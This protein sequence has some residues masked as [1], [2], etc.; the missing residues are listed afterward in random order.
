MQALPCHWTKEEG[1]YFVDASASE[2]VMLEL[3]YVH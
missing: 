1:N 2:A 3:E